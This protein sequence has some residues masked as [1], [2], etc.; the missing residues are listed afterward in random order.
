MIIPN[1]NG[2]SLLPGCLEAVLAQTLPPSEVIVVDDG[3]T[4]GS[5]DLVRARFPQVKLLA[6][7]DNVGFCR[8]A[9][10]GLRAARGDLLALL[11][12]DAEP[13]RGW[14]A[15]LAEALVVHPDVGACASKMLFYDQRSLLNSAGLFVR[16]DGMARDI[17]YGQPD[18]PQFSVPATVFGASG[19]AALYRR[20][21]LNEVGLFDED[22]VA[23]G[24]DVDLAFRAQWRGWACLYVPT[25]VVYHRVGAT[26]GRESPGTAFYRSRN[27]LIVLLKNMPARVVRRHWPIMLAAQAYQVAYLAARGHGLPALR[28]KLDALRRLRSTWGK[29]QAILRARRVTEGQIEALLGACGEWG[30]YAGVL[31]RGPG[32]V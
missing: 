18:G 19:G 13:E 31:A 22:L 28:G 25:A 16:A 14:L 8:A 15:A 30:R 2:A 6:L 21:L 11:N 5:Q 12:N 29:R 27:A 10:E 3:S 4:D 20:E 32:N 26:Y 1:Y 23:Y 7:P 24:E 9:N 17:G